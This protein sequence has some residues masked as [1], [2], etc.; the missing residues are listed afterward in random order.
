MAQPRLHPSTFPAL[1]PLQKPQAA[2]S[3]SSEKAR[4]IE[5]ASLMAP[6]PTLGSVASS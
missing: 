4:P 2:G 3:S 1:Q 5:V 6:G